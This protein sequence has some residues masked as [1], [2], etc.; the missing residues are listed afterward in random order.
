MAD[1]IS[2]EKAPTEAGLAEMTGLDVRGGGFGAVG[3]SIKTF[4]KTM[5]AGQSAGL[6]GKSSRHGL[7]Q[8]LNV[9][10]PR[11]ICFRNWSHDTFPWLQT[12][13]SAAALV[14]PGTRSLCGRKC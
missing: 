1:S 9:L 2:A 12:R 14:P 5:Q 3:A 11:M 10:N 13:P 6:E 7:N 4:A 8:P